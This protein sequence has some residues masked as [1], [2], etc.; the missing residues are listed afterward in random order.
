[1]RR[2]VK[3]CIGGYVPGGAEAFDNLLAYDIVCETLVAVWLCSLCRLWPLNYS[4]PA[5]I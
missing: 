2:A 4:G 3:L 1:V 5:S